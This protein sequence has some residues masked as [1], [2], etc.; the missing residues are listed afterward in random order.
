VVVVIAAIAGV[1]DFLT[2]HMLDK[3][4]ADSFRLMRDVYAS[5]MKSTEEKALVRAEIVSAMPAVRTAFIKR[6]RA[7][8]LEE[9]RSMFEEQSEKYGLDQAQFHLPPGISFLRLHKPDVFGDD[10]SSYRPMLVEA[11]AEKAPRRGIVVTKAGP[12]VSGIVPMADEAGKHVG[13]FEMG[14]ELAPMLDKIKAAY[15]LEV[16]VYIDEKMLRDLATDLT[17]D[18]LSEKN[19][20]GKFMRFYSTH[21]ELLRA[22]VTDR[23]VEVTDPVSYSRTVAGAPWGVQL[24][25]LY[26]Y[27]NK[28]IGV[29][30]M[31]D[32]FSE[33]RA[34]EGRTRVWL[35]LAA[36][37]G[38]IIM[39]GTILVVV[40]GLLLAPLA[41]LN[42]RMSILLRGEP[43]APAD[44]IPSYCDELRALARNYERLRS[45]KQP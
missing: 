37:F 14:L 1:S 15:E 11:N 38:V 20:V 5:I 22:L 16:G 39:S 26:N 25:P 12:A 40:R 19:R 29:V 4:E 28:Q 8:L 30:A 42:E 23:D 6:D 13:S 2:G 33:T 32:D 27:T 45:E 41:T 17:G 18:V 9:C 24:V 36:L 34:A 35:L 43:S 7:K 44:P 3:A 21:A 10:Q 31:A